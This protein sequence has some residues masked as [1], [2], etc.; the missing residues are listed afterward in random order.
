M[1]EKSKE[2][3]PEKPSQK[4]LAPLTSLPLSCDS[5]FARDKGCPSYQPGAECSLNFDKLF[6]NIQRVEALKE[7]AFDIF[8]LQYERIQRAAHFERTAGGIIDPVLSQE[9]ATFFDMMKTLKI[10]SRDTFS[11]TATGKAA[12]QLAK[13]EGIFSSLTDSK[14]K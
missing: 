1:K 2:L 14:Q 3:V 4:E 9:I 12:E 11:I 6:K 7:A 10:N 5:C 13:K 8:S